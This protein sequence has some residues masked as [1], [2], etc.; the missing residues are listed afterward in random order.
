MRKNDRII[1]IV[2]ERRRFPPRNDIGVRRQ[3]I[4]IRRMLLRR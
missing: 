2:V 1:T 4:L 3:R